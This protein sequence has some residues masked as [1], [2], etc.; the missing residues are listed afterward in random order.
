MRLEEEK[1]RLH[2]KLVLFLI[3]V[4]CAPLL[5]AQSIDDQIAAE[6]QAI[7]ALET[8]LTP[9]VK[10]L[11]VQNADVRLWVSN[12]VP[13]LVSAAFNSL[14][15]GQRHFH[16]DAVSEAGQLINSNGGGLGCGWYLTIEGGNSAHA[17]LDLSNLSA[18]VVPNGS[19]NTRV[20][21]QVAFTAQIH[22]HVKGPA[23]PCSIWN[24]WPTCNCPIGGGVG[25]SVG[26][27]GQKGDT[28][29]GNVTPRADPSNW[30]IYDVSLT[31]P[32]SI[33]ITVSVGLQY[34]GNVGIPITVNLPL[35]VLMT[36][37]APT[38][39]QNAGVVNIPNIL[40][41]Q[42]TL[43]VQPQPFTSDKTGYSV[44]AAVQINWM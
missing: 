5:F 44:K 11:L 24:P 22:A 32:S 30:L 13:P 40:N 35:G 29:S 4:G 17:D 37:T 25:T 42:Y 26:T 31:G 39:F 9:K 19:I 36:G 38:L 15:S 43:T 12:S 33:P 20:S 16:Y 21:F 27:S 10:P 18:I 41:R 23:G 1:L 8:Q 34:I 6:E 2:T 7:A 14:S 28:L 3:L